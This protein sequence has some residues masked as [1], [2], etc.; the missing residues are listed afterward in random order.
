[1]AR[2]P[3]PCSG[4]AVIGL[5][6]GSIVGGRMAWPSPCRPASIRWLWS[7]GCGL[8]GKTD[9]CVGVPGR[10]IGPV[11]G[12]GLGCGRTMMGGAFVADDVIGGVLPWPG[13][14]RPGQVGRVVGTE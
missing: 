13:C 10:I 8:C 12:V 3:A 6:R 7:I 14:G 2:P 5:F 9:C 1:M 11:V 4:W